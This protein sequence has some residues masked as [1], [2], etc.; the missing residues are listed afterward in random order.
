MATIRSSKTAKGMLETLLEYRLLLGLLAL[1]ASCAILVWNSRNILENIKTDQAIRGAG[2]ASSSIPETALP[3]PAPKVTEQSK[4]SN[5]VASPSAAKTTEAENDANAQEVKAFRI[6]AQEKCKNAKSKEEVYAINK[7]LGD[8]FVMATNPTERPRDDVRPCRYVVLDFG[9]N[10]GDTAG[11]VMDLGLK[12]CE[13]ENARPKHFNLEKH[14]VEEIQKLNPITNRL[15]EIVNSF[16]DNNIGPEDYC[17][18]G[19][20]GNPV[21]TKGLRNL[22]D[23]VLG[24]KP[25]PIRHLHFFTESVGAGED[26]MTKLYLDTVNPEKNFWGSSTFKAHQDVRKSKVDGKEVA[27]DVMGLTL[28]TIMK[29]SLKAF[30]PNASPEERKGGHLLAKIDI[31]G[32]EYALMVEAAESGVV[33]EYIKMGNSA[34]FIVEYHSQRVTGPNPLV[35]PSSKAKKK[36]EECGV[37]FR[38]LQAWWN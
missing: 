14:I 20:E 16:G 30:D 11:H 23:S 34:D 17:Y 3:N 26:G 13:K 18:Y 27:A 32:G 22:E 36:L 37:K 7:V 31:E 4:K 38:Q 1:I 33:C 10:I 29:K 25:R 8:H 24:M 21:F 28:S 6:D 12:G 35:G 9:A 15:N 2:S 19:V 5:I